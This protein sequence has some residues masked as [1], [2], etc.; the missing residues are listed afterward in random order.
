MATRGESVLIADLILIVIISYE[1]LSSNKQQQGK[2]SRSFHGHHAALYVSLS[3][4]VRLVAVH[5]EYRHLVSRRSQFLE[6]E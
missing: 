3:V 6:H 1:L 4:P 5:T 2:Y